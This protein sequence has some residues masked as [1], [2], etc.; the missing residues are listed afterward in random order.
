VGQTQ[1]QRLA[2]NIFDNDFKSTFK[3]LYEHFK[4]YSELS[5]GPQGQIRVRVGI[6]KNIKAF[7]QWTPRDEIRLAR[8]PSTT[9]FPVGQVTDLIRGYKTHKKFQ[10]DS[11]TFAEA[12]K[13]G[14]FTE[15]TKWEDWKPTFL[16]Y[17]R[18]IPGRDGIP[19]KYVCREADEPDPLTAHDD[20]IDNYVAMA[21]VRGGSYAIDTV[22]VHTFLVN[23]VAGDDTAEAKIQG[24]QRVNNG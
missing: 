24:L 6:R 12:A 21:H 22:Q 17:I 5:A 4:S 11:K 7:L 9:P 16:N 1:A 18:S 13:P 20:F 3:E 14:N 10:S 19:S 2:E 15:S 23:F 8:D